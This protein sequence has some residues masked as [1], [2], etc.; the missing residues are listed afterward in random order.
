MLGTPGWGA[1]ESGFELEPL[2]LRKQDVYSFGLLVWAIALNGI[3][4]WHMLMRVADNVVE[5]ANSTQRAES[6]SKL[7]YVEFDGLKATNN[8]DLLIKLAKETL[9]QCHPGDVD[10]CTVEYVLH[11]TLC[12][13]LD[14]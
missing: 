3:K 2:E 8:G 12:N 5:V 13:D 11:Q 14:K 9:E 10:Y 6:H 4:P 7:T 1:P